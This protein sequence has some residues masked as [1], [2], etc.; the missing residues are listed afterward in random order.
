MVVNEAGASVYSASE[1]AAE[2]LP[3]MDVSL[4]GAVSIA[5]RLQVGGPGLSSYVMRTCWRTNNIIPSPCHPLSC[6]APQPRG[7]LAPPCTR[8]FGPP[9]FAT[10]LPSFSLLVSSRRRE[11]NFIGI[12]LECATQCDM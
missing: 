7:A 2:E 11:I 4:R 10:F 8:A 1:L 9:S 5:R 6:P 12:L 3:G